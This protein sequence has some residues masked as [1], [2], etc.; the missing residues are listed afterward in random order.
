MQVMRAVNAFMMYICKRLY[1]ATSTERH[2]SDE[3]NYK[4]RQVS[5]RLGGN[6]SRVRPPRVQVMWA[7]STF[8]ISRTA[9]I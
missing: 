6:T 2:P 9:L 1:R 5:E 8:D 4:L 3:C 7:V